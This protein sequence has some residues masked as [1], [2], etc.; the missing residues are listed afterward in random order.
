MTN[1]IYLCAADL[2]HLK[3][4]LPQTCNCDYAPDGTE[5]DCAVCQTLAVINAW[6]SEC[7]EIPD[8]VA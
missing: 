7:T 1:Y 5:I 8:K 2:E 6:I 4:L 3:D